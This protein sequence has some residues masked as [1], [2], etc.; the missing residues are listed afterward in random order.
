MNNQYLASA[1]T[2]IHAP[3]QKVWQALT[4]A[5]I[6]KQYFFGSDIVTDWK[7]GS[8]IFY[9]GTWQGKPFEDK[10][11]VV[12]VNPKNYSWSLTGRLCP[13]RPIPLKTITL[14]VTSSRRR[15]AGRASLSR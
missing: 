5:A 15:M 7:V 9:R 14:F 3:A 6:I 10:G 4:D 12:K 8:P 13:V 11:T 2:T 1:T